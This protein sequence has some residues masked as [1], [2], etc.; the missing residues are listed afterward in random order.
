MRVKEGF[1]S[2]V[3]ALKLV[4]TP[5]DVLVSTYFELFPKGDRD[6]FTRI[7]ELRVYF[8]VIFV[9]LFYFISISLFLVFIF[10]LLRN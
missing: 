5:Y 8:F 4:S 2:T 9:F 7:V 1:A 6:L 3:K 10:M